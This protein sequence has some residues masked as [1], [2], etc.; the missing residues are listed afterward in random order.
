MEPERRG[1]E[2]EIP[3]SQLNRSMIIMAPVP[4]SIVVPFMAVA[5]FMRPVISAAFSNFTPGCSQQTS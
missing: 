2:Y 4:I 3:R 5:I 1:K